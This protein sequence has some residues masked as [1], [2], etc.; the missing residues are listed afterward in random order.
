ML[1][2]SLRLWALSHVLLA[3]APM[4]WRGA[5]PQVLEAFCLHYYEATKE[6][7]ECGAERFFLPQT[8]SECFSLK[9]R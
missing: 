3:A 6:P 2:R 1:P 4:F 5:Q 9:N 8:C 7:Q